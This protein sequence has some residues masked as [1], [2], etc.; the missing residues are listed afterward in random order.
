MDMIL[1]VTVTLLPKITWKVLL[2]IYYR[3]SSNNNNN[4][5]YDDG[6]G[7]KIPKH[8]NQNW[9]MEMRK[10]TRGILS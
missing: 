3:G 4:Y 7:K 1:S 5:Y 10:K 6:K 9:K 2:G 8:T